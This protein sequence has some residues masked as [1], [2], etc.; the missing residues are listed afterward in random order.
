MR[1]AALEFV[2]LFL[3]AKD[4]NPV[5]GDLAECHLEFSRALAADA[6]R[7][8]LRELRRAWM[9]SPAAMLFALGAALAMYGIAFLP[10]WPRTEAGAALWAIAI[11]GAVLEGAVPV[12]AAAW[13]SP[14]RPGAAPFCLVLGMTALFATSADPGRA[15]VAFAVLTASTYAGM[16]LGWRAVRTSVA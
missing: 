14:H 4:R 6:V 7:I 3:T 15:T 11:A 13:L 2:A 1:D 9:E 8:V 16:Y 10:A 5:L 12:A